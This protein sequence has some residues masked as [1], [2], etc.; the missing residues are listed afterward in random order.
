MWLQNNLFLPESTTLVCLCCSDKKLRRDIAL[1]VYCILKSHRDQISQIVITGWDPYKNWVSEAQMIR[2]QIG[3]SMKWIEIILE[4]SSNNTHENA[5]N[6][7][8]LLGRNHDHICLLWERSHLPRAL[9]EFISSWCYVQQ[10]IALQDILWKNSWYC[11]YDKA[12]K[13]F[14]KRYILRDLQERVWFLKAVVPQQIIDIIKRA[15]FPWK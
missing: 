10:T 1:A 2:E 11:W 4:E 5:E 7:N 8:Q 13:K 12:P 3:W 6:V 9:K 14:V 15:A